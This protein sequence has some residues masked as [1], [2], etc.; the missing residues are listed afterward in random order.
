MTSYKYKGEKFSDDDEDSY[1]MNSD[2][3]AKECVERGASLLDRELPGWASLIDMGTLKLA[4]PCNCIAGQLGCHLVADWD[5]DYRDVYNLAIEK[6]GV[7][8]FDENDEADD[9]TL[10]GFECDHHLLTYGRLQSNWVDQINKRLD[11]ANK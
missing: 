6:L 5:E 10:H 9:A 7:G 8:R 1:E 3:F 4:S 11:G 2:G